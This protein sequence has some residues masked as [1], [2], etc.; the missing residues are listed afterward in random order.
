[1]QEPS[2]AE[3]W[4]REHTKLENEDHLPPLTEVLYFLL[5]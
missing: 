5:D 2:P 1:L 4:L 3:K